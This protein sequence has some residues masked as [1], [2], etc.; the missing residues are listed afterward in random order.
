MLHGVH[1]GR[2]TETF[3]LEGPVTDLPPWALFHVGIWGLNWLDRLRDSL[4][5]PHVRVMQMSLEF[6]RPQARAVLPGPRTLYIPCVRVYTCGDDPWK[7][8]LFQRKGGSGGLT[9]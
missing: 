7:G 4:T 6:M 8:L 2:A 5:P 3:L 9:T 1:T